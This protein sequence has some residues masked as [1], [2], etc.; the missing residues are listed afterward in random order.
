M[1]VAFFKDASVSKDRVSMS[2]VSGSTEYEAC[3]GPIQRK[4]GYVDCPRQLIEGSYS[5]KLSINGQ[6]VGTYPFQVVD[7]DRIKRMIKAVRMSDQVRNGRPPADTRIFA[8]NSTVGIYI[9]YAES[10]GDTMSMRSV[11]NGTTSVICKDYQ[12]SPSLGSNSYYCDWHVGRAGDYSI[13]AVIDGIDVGQYDYT[14]V[15]VKSPTLPEPLEPNA[16]PSESSGANAFQRGKQGHEAEA[17]NSAPQHES[18]IPGNS[19]YA[20]STSLSDATNNAPTHQRPDN[21]ARYQQLREQQEFWQ[22]HGR[23]LVLREHLRELRS[24]RHN[25]WDSHRG[26]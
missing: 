1:L 26:H 12:L 20:P 7:T 13:I 18:E 2:V 8:A 3:A 17:A 15:D 19:H 9:D 11:W 4:E 6:V 5:F 22:R 14:V 23:G 25:S 21:G 16:S 24:A 10:S